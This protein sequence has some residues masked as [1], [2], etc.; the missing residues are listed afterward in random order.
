VT[1]GFKGSIVNG[2]AEIGF[3]LIIL[4]ILSF[5]LICL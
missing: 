1:R 5:F 4:L 2:Q 3:F